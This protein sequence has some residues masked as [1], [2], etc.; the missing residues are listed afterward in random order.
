MADKERIDRQRMARR[1][2]QEFRAGEV[3]GLGPGLPSLIPA[4][5][6]GDWGVWFLA[7]SGALGFRAAA[8]ASPPASQES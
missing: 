5:V 4:Q 3:V 2:A 1:V 8:G 6:P 7:D